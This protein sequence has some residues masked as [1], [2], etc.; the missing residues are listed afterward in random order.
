MNVVKLSVLYPGRLYPQEIT[1]VLVSVRGRVDPSATLR[2]EGSNQWKIPVTPSGIEPATFR[3]VAQCLD[4]LCH[5][6]PQN[7]FV[8]NIKLYE[9][10]KCVSIRSVLNRSS[11]RYFN[12]YNFFHIWIFNVKKE[13]V[14][15]LLFYIH[16]KWGSSSKMKGKLHL[17]NMHLTG[18]WLCT[19]LTNF[20]YCWPCILV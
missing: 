12:N 19:D 2:L 8:Y 6:V 17:E 5:R 13:K 16:N 14:Y 18:T 10:K 7:K 15:T 1:L 4:Q 3:L 20:M 9:Y 11:V